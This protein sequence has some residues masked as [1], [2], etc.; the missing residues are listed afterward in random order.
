MADNIKKNKMGFALGISEFTEVI[1]R[2]KYYAD[3]TLFIRDFID[4]DAQTTL[5]TRPRRFGKTLN[6]T[7]LRTFF[8]KPLD[9][10]DTSHYF[11][12]L[13]IWQAGEEYRLEQGK[14]PVIYLTFKDIKQDNYEDALFNIKKKINQEFERHCELAESSSLSTSN[15]KLYAA[16]SERMTA[17]NEYAAAIE[18]LSEML[19]KHYKQQVV[20][21]LD[22]YDVPIQSGFECG[23]YDKIIR[24]MRTL[25]SGAFKDN[26]NLYKGALTGVTRVSKESIFSG[27][28]N[29]DVDTIFDEKFCAYFGFTQEEIN[30]M[31]RFHGIEDKLKEAEEWY[32]GYIF[33]NKHIYNPW[34]IINYISKDCKPANYWVNV[35]QNGLAG[36]AIRSLDKTEKDNLIKLLKDEEPRPRVD[37][38]TNMVYMD[39]GK[40][41]ADA[42]G[43]L[44]Q[45]GYLTA[46]D[47]VP[48][49][50]T[51]LSTIKIPN[52]ELFAAYSEE[53]IDRM[54]SGN[55]SN[56]A[57]KITN[58]IIDGREKDLQKS[59]SDFLMETCSYL[60][61][62]EE[63]DYQN[64][65]I[66]LLASMKRGYDITLEKETGLGRADIILQPRIDNWDKRILPG[67]I[68]ELK[69]YEAAESD[70]NNPEKIKAALEKEAEEALKQIEKKEYI[71]KMRSAGVKNVIKYGVAAS[72]KQVCVKTVST[73]NK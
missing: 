54:L 71:A 28:N 65:L 59:L 36:E 38:S 29:L 2:K 1:G 19:F 24:F 62:T 17:D 42:Y 15:K 23:Y 49:S 6:M 66:A 21:L 26:P 61:L 50:R 70:K 7:M 10:K 44:A 52:R 58:A 34:S 53:V 18:T 68:I 55:A 32:D 43:L 16:M 57:N 60:T 13:K 9:G 40:K 51:Y 30:E 45:T 67:I 47:S 35:S 4:A 73:S 63:K 39:F 41:S 37:I 31:F 8:E 20:I 22:E 11:K 12:N 69:H 3:K 48:K 46:I 5:F 72:G 14:Y 25:L 56:C 27:L 33:G 64:I